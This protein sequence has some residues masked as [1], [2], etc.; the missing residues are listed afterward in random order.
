MSESLEQFAE[1]LAGKSPVPAGGSVAAIAAALAA[2]LPAMI[3]RIALDKAGEAGTASLRQMVEQSDILT[4]RLFGLAAED[5][6]AY[7]ALLEA[8]RN[9]TGGEAERDERI[10]KA[11]R[12]AAQAPA[13]TIKLSREVAQLARRAAREGPPSTVG[14]AVM[15]ALLAAAAAAGAMVNLRLNVQAAGRP[16]DLRVLEDNMTVI[17]RDAQRAAMETR[18]LVELKLSPVAEKKDDEMTR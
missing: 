17:L 14:D 11:W 16:V 12:R 8:R 1:R 2:A 7:L 5:A 6:E 4:G 3:G 9:H 10:R 18:Q 13:E 15:A